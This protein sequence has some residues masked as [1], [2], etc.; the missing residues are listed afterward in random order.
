MRIMCTH[1][2]RYL[3]VQ[4]HPNSQIYLNIFVHLLRQ[5]NHVSTQKATDRIDSMPNH[6]YSSFSFFANNHH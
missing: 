4:Q 5:D 6:H 1:H 3:S 2:L